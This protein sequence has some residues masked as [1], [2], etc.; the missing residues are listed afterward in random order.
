MSTTTSSGTLSKVL[1]TMTE[2][3]IGLA[4]G[5]AQGIDPKTAA[6]HPEVD[7]K[8][9][10]CNHP[11]FVFGHLAIYPQMIMQT[12][13]ADVGD[14]AMPESYQELFKNGAECLDDPESS[15]YPSF[16]EVLGNCIRAHKAVHEYIKGCDDASL[17]GP[18]EGN[19]NAAAFF[20][21]CEGMTIFML[22]DHFM[23]HLGQLSTWRR[24]MGLGSAM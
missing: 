15:I 12:L 13:G 14:T 24:V 7:G 16:E 6:R 2:R 11:T 18:I 22:H 21:T 8:P 17:C 23:F 4:E 19:E 10:M 20:G 5:L 1:L 9:I 3:T